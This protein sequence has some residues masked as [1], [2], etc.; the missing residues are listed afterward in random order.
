MKNVISIQSHVVYGHAGNSAAVFPMRRVGVEVWPLNA[1]QFSNHTQY[2]EG[3]KGLVFPPDHLVSIGVGLEAIGVL[4]RCD[5]VLT[6]YIGSAEQGAAVLDIVARIK[7]AN[8]GAIF[9]CDP[10]MGHPVKGCKVAPGVAE[11][12]RDQSVNAADMMSPNVLELGT[13][14]GR[15]LDDV[16][17]CLAAAREVMER[18]PRLILVKHLAYAAEDKNAFEMILATPDEAWHISRPLI[19]FERQP[20]GVGDLTSGLL[21]ASLLKGMPYREALEF[22]AASVYEVILATKKAKAYELQLVAAQDLIAR[23]EHQFVATKL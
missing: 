11:F 10:V 2:A 17:A 3:W 12:H 15:E 1:V 13:L 14:V 20:V 16:P 19:D 23:P 7:T 8:P 21:L 6:G 9:F 18:G 22:T 5:A 4:S